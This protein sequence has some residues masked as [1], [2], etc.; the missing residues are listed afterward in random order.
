MNIRVVGLAVAAIALAGCTKTV[1][2]D[3]PVPV[4]VAVPTSSP[5]VPD[6]LGPQPEYPDTD[7]ALKGV[8]PAVRYQLIAT[9]RLLRIARLAEIEPIV[10][11][12]PRGK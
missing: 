3:R 8:D 6:T 4:E 11:A 2:V 1:Y 7:G 5:C 10:A 9:G 12:C